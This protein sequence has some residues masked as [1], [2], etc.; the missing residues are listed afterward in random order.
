MWGA[1]Y[2]W[3]QHDLTKLVF[4]GTFPYIIA[5]FIAYLVPTIVP[6]TV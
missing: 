3:I 5:D 4:Q 2:V 6:P 1:K